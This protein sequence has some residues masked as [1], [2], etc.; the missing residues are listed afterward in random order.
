MRRFRSLILTLL[1]VFLLSSCGVEDRRYTYVRYFGLH[2]Q[3]MYFVLSDKKDDYKSHIYRFEGEEFVHL[4]EFEEGFI[5]LF[6]EGIF[7]AMTNNSDGTLTVV[8]YN[9]DSDVTKEYILSDFP[10]YL[11]MMNYHD[12]VLMFYTGGLQITGDESLVMYSTETNEI[13]TSIQGS[14]IDLGY[15]VGDFDETYIY[16]ARERS[17]ST[18]LFRGIR[19]NRETNAIELYQSSGL[20]ISYGYESNQIFYRTHIST[21]NVYAM[22]KDDVPYKFFIKY[23]NYRLRLFYD[24]NSETFIFSNNEKGTIEILNNGTFDTYDVYY[25]EYSYGFINDSV[26]YTFAFETYG[27]FFKREIVNIEIRSIVSNEILYSS[28]NITIGNQIKWEER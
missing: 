11:R 27:S 6:S 20:Y 9:V 19:I 1:I 25:N 16:L 14:V 26:Y 15:G 28:G 22:S 7:F 23:N 12:N 3:D 4:K 10:P 8:E 24:L 5:T 17:N 21:S 13:I 2:N 18:E